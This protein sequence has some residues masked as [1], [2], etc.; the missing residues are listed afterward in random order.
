MTIENLYRI[1]IDSQRLF[2]CDKNK[3]IYL[4]QGRSVNIPISYFD[5]LIKNI[6]TI[7]TNNGSALIITVE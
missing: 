4:W 2:I 5:R 6:Y 7:T 1:L 3:E